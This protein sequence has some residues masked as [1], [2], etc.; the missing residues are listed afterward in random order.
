[1]TWLMFESV[2]RLRAV[3]KDNCRHVPEKR[4]PSAQDDSEMGRQLK[5]SGPL[6]DQAAGT[7]G[8][9]GLFVA[10]AAEL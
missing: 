2:L 7:R 4:R 8:A 10:A 5:R 9:K 3:V 6:A 1:M